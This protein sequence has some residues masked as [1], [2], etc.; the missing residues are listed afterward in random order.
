MKIQSWKMVVV[1][2]LSLDRA[3]YIVRWCLGL[4]PETLV[5]ATF[6]SSICY[7]ESNCPKLCM[8]AFSAW[9]LAEWLLAPSFQGY[10]PPS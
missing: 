3:V 1:M 9:L 2:V 5:L 8:T 7:H 4:W 6:F 10:Y